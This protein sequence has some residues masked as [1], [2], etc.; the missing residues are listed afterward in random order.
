MTATQTAQSAS[1][2]LSQTQ[3]NT[4]AALASI[5]LPSNPNPD[6]AQEVAAHTLR[7]GFVSPSTRED[8]LK[9]ARQTFSTIVDRAIRRGWYSTYSASD[10]A[11]NLD[12]IRFNALHLGF[13]PCSY[14]QHPDVRRRLNAKNTTFNT[15]FI[16]YGKDYLEALFKSL[17]GE[18]FW[19]Q[20]MAH[21][22][23]Q[24]AFYTEC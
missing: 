5:G 17:V 7:F 6:S 14:S 24:R 15:L 10:L 8:F 3:N 21:Y 1:Q 16:T 19:A 4:N 11:A 20:E 22:N 18:S 12:R 9:Q 23:A 13:T 2:T